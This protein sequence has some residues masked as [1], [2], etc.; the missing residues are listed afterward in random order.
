MVLVVALRPDPDRSPRRP[1]RGPAGALPKQTSSPNTRTIS[2]PHLALIIGE[3]PTAGPTLRP[4]PSSVGLDGY[5]PAGGAQVRADE[6]APRK[7]KNA[8]TSR[9]RPPGDQRRFQWVN[10]YATGDW[11]TLLIHAH[12]DRETRCGWILYFKLWIRLQDKRIIAR[13]WWDTSAW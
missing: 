4:W 10:V 2:T 3:T 7:S 9:R 11:D 5:W 8:L 1:E 6:P 12:T 13:G